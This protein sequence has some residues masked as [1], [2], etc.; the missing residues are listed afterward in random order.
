MIERGRPVLLWEP[1]SSFLVVY[2]PGRR[3]DTHRGYLILPEGLSYGDPIETSS[4]HKFLALIPS[5]SELSMKVRR[6]TT[7]L[8][9]KDIGYLIMETGV[10]A[11]QSVLEVGTGSGALTLVL[12][13]IVGDKGRVYSFERRPEFLENAKKNLERW[14]LAHRVEFILRDPAEEGFGLRGVQVAIVDVPEPWTIVRPAREAIM[15]GGF[16]ASLSPCFEQV[17]RVVEELEASGF[18]ALKTVELLER[19]ILVRPGKT[20][21]RERM[22]SHT[23]YLTVARKASESSAVR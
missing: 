1:K 11:G 16:W 19:E 12:A 14:G 4:G 17:I 5:L 9:P 13:M 21:P 15:G 23:G 18:V 10:S 20:R 2:E 7:I 3:L 22:V 6:T 8:Y